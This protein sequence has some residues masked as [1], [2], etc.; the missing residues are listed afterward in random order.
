LCFFQR[1]EQAVQADAE[2]SSSKKNKDDLNTDDLSGIVFELKMDLA[3][4]AFFLD[5]PFILVRI[6]MSL[7]GK[8]NQ[9]SFFRKR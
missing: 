2:V 8:D 6:S 3:G 5:V 1:D 9:G 7:N 4:I